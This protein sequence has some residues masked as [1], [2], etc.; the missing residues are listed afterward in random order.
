MIALSWSRV[1][2][3]LQCARK[4]HL[5]YIAKS[6]PHEDAT[7]SVH[8]VKGAEMHKQLEHYVYDKINGVDTS[9]KPFSPACKETLPM[10]DKV[11]GSFGQVWPERQIAVNQD[12]KQVE[13]FAKDTAWRAIWDFSAILEKLA[14]IIDWK[15]GKV[16]DYDIDEPGQLHLSAAMAMDVYGVEEVMVFYAYI[17]HKVKKPEEG[18]RLTKKDN[19]QPIRSY[20]TQILDRVNSE[21]EWK[22]TVNQFCN[23]CPATKAQCPFSRKG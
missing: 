6:F 17:E 20:F 13:W 10:I 2:D 22:P 23:Y 18:L 5:K 14:L 16:Q 21:T 9:Q 11:M 12:W 19:Y 8:L 7:K 4:F 1:S 3:Y 15:T